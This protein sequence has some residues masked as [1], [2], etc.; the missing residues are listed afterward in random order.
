MSDEND[1][2]DSWGWVDVSEEDAPSLETE[3]GREFWTDFLLE[4]HA[5]DDWCK[6]QVVHDGNRMLVRFRWPDGSEELFDL[7]IEKSMQVVRPQGGEGN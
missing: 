1:N 6:A 4:E 7:V 3:E 2:D 5:E